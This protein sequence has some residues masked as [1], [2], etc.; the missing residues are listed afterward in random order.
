M[1][2]RLHLRAE[3]PEDLA[4]LSALLQ[5]MAVRASDIGWSQQG[6]RLAFVGNRYRWEAQTADDGIQTRVRCALR[7]DFVDHV[8]RRDWPMATDT[9]MAMLAI[10]LEPENE[11]LIIFSGGPMLRLKAETIDITL[12]DLSG[13]WGTPSV[14]RHA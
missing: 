11:L 5:D 7:F 12:E 10:T 3:S 8:Q 2:E 13:P 1:S 6:R 9:V 14:P 4:P